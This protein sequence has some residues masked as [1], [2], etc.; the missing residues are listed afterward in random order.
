LLFLAF[1]TFGVLLRLGNPDL[2][3]P[4]KGGEK[5]MDFSYFNAVLKSTSFPP[6]DPWFAGGYINYYYYG[7]VL[8][9]VLVKWL[10]IVPSI[11]INL[12][13]PTIFSLIAMGAFSI[14]WNLF[15]KNGARRFPDGNG[16]FGQSFLKKS[17]FIPAIAA[18]L[19]MAVLGNLGTLRMI[20]HGYQKL[21]APE[22]TI[23]DAGF[24]TS[25]VWTG[26]GFV[27]ALLGAKLP[28]SLADWYWIPSR[29]VPPAAGEVEVITEFPFF[30]VLYADPHAHLFAL[31]LT[32]L[33]IAWAVSVV[34]GR[35]WRA[36]H[37]R[38]T[39]NANLKIGLGFLIGGLT[40]GALR[41]TNTW[42]LP[43]YLALGVV[44]LGYTIGRYYCPD[45][46]KA[47]LLSNLSQRSNWILVAAGSIGLL[48]GLAFIL[49]QPYSHWYVQGYSTIELWRGSRTPIWSY[50][51]HWGV[52]LFVIASWMAWETRDWMAS[53]PLSALRKLKS[54]RDLILGGLI[55]FLVLI[56]GM[57]LFG[58]H[59]AWLVLLLATWMG[60]L[61]FRP[62]SSDAKR[63]VLFLAGTGLILTLMVELVVLRG[64]VGR[65]NTVFKF[66]LQGWTLLAIS[67]AASL[68]WIISSLYQWNH[69]WR[70][71]WRALLVLLLLSA[72]LYPLLGGVAKIK[73]RMEPEAPRSL[74][75]M[76]YMNYATYHDLNTVMD[77]SQ[78]YRA[79]RWIQENITGTPVI[80]EANLS[81]YRWGTRYTIYTGLPNVIGW[82]WHQRQQRAL[83]PAN[84]VWDRVT[85][86]NE[87]YLTPHVE[88]VQA[89]LEKYGVRYIILGQLER[90]AYP[91]PGLEKFESLDG[92]LWTAVYRDQE[93][94]IYEVMENR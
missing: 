66:Y 19:G 53:T 13:L 74:D 81:E 68:G 32:L 49:F 88:E 4:W 72:A 90:A 37:P 46:N 15:D 21:V 92:T 82:N 83:A 51:T 78:D 65:M 71:F 77:L 25:L 86:V 67:A 23:T 5:P 31:P 70:L 76:A 34:L 41:P 60:V 80:V 57:T 16:K 36:T 85:E 30:T 6:Y 18:A 58:V 52:F 20:L 10:G 17:A 39:P 87:F 48:V 94:V 47:G 3:H 75:G 69:G 50:L 1:F 40:I 14:G 29:V 64:D 59:I 8:T 62:G 93:T 38:I 2:W 79:I 44:A 24:L 45:P 84:L 63:V 27:Q 7:F 33:A 89:F 28:F 12:I 56:G 91:G 55:A 26:Q 9:G 22:G 11:A 42:D 54:Y 61:I 35:A 43:T 73:D